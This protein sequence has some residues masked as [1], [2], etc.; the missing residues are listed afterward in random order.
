MNGTRCIHRI[1]W[2]AGQNSYFDR[3]GWFLVSVTPWNHQ[4]GSIMLYAVLAWPGSGWMEAC[5]SQFPGASRSF[6]HP[7][8]VSSPR[9][10]T[11]ILCCFALLTWN[12]IFIRSLKQR[13]GICRIHSL[14]LSQLFHLKWWLLLLMLLLL[15]MDALTFLF[16][17]P[18]YFRYW[19]CW[20]ES[21]Y[22]GWFVCF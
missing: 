10:L 1:L 21:E 22:L 16:V 2:A 18:S 4:A 8:G 5:P 9:A 14:F 11:N 19:A 7:M 12:F 6:E 20:A 3:L 13:R 17:D 15:L